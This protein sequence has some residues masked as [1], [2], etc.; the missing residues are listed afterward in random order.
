MCSRLSSLAI[1]LLLT[2][3]P[4][5]AQLDGLEQISSLARVG[6]FGVVVDVEATATLAANPALDASTLRVLLGDRIAAVSGRRPS[7]DPLETGHP[8]VYV[9]INAIDVADGLVP[10][11]VNASFI[12]EGRLASGG[13]PINMTTWESGSVGLVSH[14]R[15][16]A[17]A[18]TALGLVEEFAGDLLMAGDG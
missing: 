13:G 17:I 1:V 7:M 6:R 18:E 16:R 12:Q 14:D 11:A 10:F 2:V 9:H 4:A 15:I 5:A 8:Y 3:G